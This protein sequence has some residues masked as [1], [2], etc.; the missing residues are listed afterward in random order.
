MTKFIKLIYKMEMTFYIK[1]HVIDILLIGDGYFNQSTECFCENYTSLSAVIYF[2]LLFCK[3][4]H[5]NEN[6]L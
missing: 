3:P 1:I 5:S 2:K 4:K 6:I